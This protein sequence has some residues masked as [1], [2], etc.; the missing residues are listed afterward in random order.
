MD[1]TDNRKDKEVAME[2]EMK[3]NEDKM[4]IEEAKD[5][6]AQGMYHLYC[7]KC[8]HVWY[9]PSW[10]TWCPKWGCTGRAKRM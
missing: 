7:P 5:A 10:D 2:A 9:S 4:P 3:Q 1:N 6:E 8:G